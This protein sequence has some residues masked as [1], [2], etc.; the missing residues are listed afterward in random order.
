MATNVFDPKKFLN[1]KVLS[2]L[3]N[4]KIFGGII[5][6]DADKQKQKKKEK[7]KTLADLL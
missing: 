4:S 3:E 2:P 5:A 7:Q 6:D 1:I